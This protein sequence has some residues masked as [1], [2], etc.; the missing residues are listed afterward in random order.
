MW[1]MEYGKEWRAVCSLF[2]RTSWRNGGI[3]R[4]L[5]QSWRRSSTGARITSLKRADRASVG[6]KQEPLCLFYGIFAQI[7][8]KRSK[9]ARDAS[10]K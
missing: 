6:L 1:R 2:Y 10:L 3:A 7:E 5:A 4:V 8:R 9:N